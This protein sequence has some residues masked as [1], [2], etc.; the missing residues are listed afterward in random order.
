MIERKAYGRRNAWV[1]ELKVEA[2]ARTHT[3]SN[4]FHYK[5]C[6]LRKAE[7]ISLCRIACG[8]S[9]SVVSMQYSHRMI[10]RSK[11]QCCVQVHLFK[12]FTSLTKATVAAHCT[13]YNPF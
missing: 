12:P 6:V 7:R 1:H 10:Q 13:E 5:A 3:F 11:D 9:T 4:R 2:V 8:H